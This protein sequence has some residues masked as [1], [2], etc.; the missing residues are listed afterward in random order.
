M[1]EK[2]NRK[3]CGNHLSTTNFLAKYGDDEKKIAN[4]DIFR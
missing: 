3:K 1:H 2:C 4:S